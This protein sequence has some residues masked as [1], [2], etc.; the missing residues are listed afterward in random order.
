METKTRSIKELLQVMLDN[1]DL[2][3]DGLCLWAI[4]L[5]IG[6]KITITERE[7]LSAYIKRN[8][9]FRF[10]TLETSWNCI[11]AYWWNCGNIKPRIKWIEKHIKLNS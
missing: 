4:S 8:R 2:F 11:G 9:P 5:S 3:K 10:S 6:R 7:L 1:Q